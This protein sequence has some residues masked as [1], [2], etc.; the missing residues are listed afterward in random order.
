M[1]FAPPGHKLPAGHVVQSD[2]NAKPEYNEYLPAP[3]L[4]ES[5]ELKLTFLIPTVSTPNT[6]L[7]SSEISSPVTTALFKMRVNVPSKS[8]YAHAVFVTAL[9]KT[10]KTPSGVVLQ[11][12]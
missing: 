11:T 12:V 1:M 3:Q 9:A 2:S 8:E 5:A 10:T 6:R 7:D 4:L